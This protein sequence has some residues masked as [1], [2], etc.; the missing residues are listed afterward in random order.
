M[1]EASGSSIPTRYSGR[2]VRV[3][4]ACA[5]AVALASLTTGCP[6]QARQHEASD[7]YVFERKEFMH[8]RFEV[9]IVEHASF[10]ELLEALPNGGPPRKIRK[11]KAWSKI[12]PDGTCEIHIVDQAKFYTP[13]AIGHELA[14][15]IYGRWHS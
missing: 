14:H 6:A 5:G 13:D 7:G 10:A 11:V 1:A 15:C 4:A 8:T 9:R 3:A 12:E 2:R